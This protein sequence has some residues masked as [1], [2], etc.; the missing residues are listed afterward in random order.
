MNTPL[1]R[2]L[3]IFLFLA[4]AAIASTFFVEI[5]PS[6]RYDLSQVDRNDVAVLAWYQR[7]VGLEL[8]LESESYD[9]KLQNAERL[10]T[11]D[12]YRDFVFLLH[13]TKAIEYLKGA[14]VSF[15]I[16]TDPM[17]SVIAHGTENDIFTWLL[18]GDAE[19]EILFESNRI[20]YPV[21]LRYKISRSADENAFFG[22]KIGGLSLVN[23]EQQTN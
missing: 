5:E 13:Q 21:R 15:S 8:K 9:Q 4:C 19:I 2:G 18:E 3:I 20:T 23:Q 12:G 11:A 22:L 17:P 6:R 7:V 10:F 16:S 1:G 14:N